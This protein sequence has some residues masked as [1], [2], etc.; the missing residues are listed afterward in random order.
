MRPKLVIMNWS[1]LLVNNRKQIDKF[2]YLLLFFSFK[3]VICDN[4]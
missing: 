1:G 2:A 3:L 4:L